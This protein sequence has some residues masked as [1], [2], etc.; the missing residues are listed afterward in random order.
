[1]SAVLSVRDLNVRFSTPEG[2][3]EAVSNVNFDVDEGECLGVVGESGS[4]KSQTFMAIMGLLAG[5]GKA[6][7]SAKFHGQELLNMPARALNKI[8]GSRMTMIFQDPMTSLTPH[9]KISRQLTE[10]LV[11]HKG[12]SETDARRRALEM[13]ELVKIPDAKRRMDMY[14]HEFSG[15]MRQRVMIAMALLCEPELLIADEPSTAL[16]VTVQAQILELFQ[17]LKNTTGSQGK[18]LAIIMITHDLGVVAGLC[19]R[20]KV[21]YA[22]AFCEVGTVHNIFD[23]PQH[24][25]SRGLLASVPRMDRPA[26]ERLRAIRGQPPNLQRLPKGCT[27]QERCDYRFDRCVA[28]RPALLEFAPGRLKTC[29]LKGFAESGEVLK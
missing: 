28:E 14:P 17:D 13:L 8:R 26:D 11:I 23:D 4:G 7:G 16:D 27:F 3:V 15:G 20:V 19:D 12:M 24:P 6:T 1:M 22:G 21:M 29:H 25:Y 5:N 18:K 9:L 10:V 2:A